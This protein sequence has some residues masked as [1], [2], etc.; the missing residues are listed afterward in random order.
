LKAVRIF[1]HSRWCYALG[2][3]LK[4]LIHLCFHLAPTITTRRF[5]TLFHLKELLRIHKGFQLLHYFLQPLRALL[6]CKELA[7]SLGK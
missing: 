2:V 1:R 7:L 4:S 3:P 6:Q 5:L